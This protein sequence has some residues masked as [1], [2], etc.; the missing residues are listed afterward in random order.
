MPFIVLQLQITPFST[1]STL[2]EQIHINEHKTVLYSFANR[3]RFI[4]SLVHT[5]SHTNVGRINS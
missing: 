1:I 3:N 4:M 2:L 5:S